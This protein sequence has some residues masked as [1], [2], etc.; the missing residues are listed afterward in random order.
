MMAAGRVRLVSNTLSAQ[1]QRGC[2]VLFEVQAPYRGAE[3]PP[4]RVTASATEL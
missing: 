1:A 4:K 3:N 2:G